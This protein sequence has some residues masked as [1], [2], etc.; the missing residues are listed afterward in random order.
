MNLLKKNLSLLRE[1][2]P[3]LV[4]RVER[5]AKQK[6]VR[7]IFSKDGKPIPQISSV[8]LHSNYYPIEEAVRSLNSFNIKQ[9]ENPVIYGLGF[10]YHVLE[11]QKINPGKK[12]IVIEP[13]MAIF[14]SFIETIDIKPFLKNIIFVVNEPPAKLLVSYDINNWK[15]FKHLPSIRISSAYFENLDKAKKACTYINNNKLKILVINPFYGGSLPTAQYCAEAL[16]SLGHQV[17]TVKC[18]NFVEGTWF[19]PV[20]THK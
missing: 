16:I 8:S 2:Q 13:E 4:R 18:E 7:V 5:E 17:D 15:V 1:L 19:N 12:I 9:N 3:S 6:L 14:L 11:I 20:S 10:G